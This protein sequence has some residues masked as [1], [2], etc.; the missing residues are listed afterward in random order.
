MKTVLQISCMTTWMYLTLLLCTLRLRW[1]IVCSMYFTISKNHFLNFLIF[2][3]WYVLLFFS[4][5]QGREGSR[6]HSQPS[7]STP[8][9]SPHP[10]IPDSSSIYSLLSIP[11]ALIFIL[12][13]TLFVFL[14]PMYVTIQSP[15]FSH[16]ESSKTENGSHYTFKKAQTPKQA[17][18]QGLHNLITGDLTTHPS[19]PFIMAQSYY[20][21][22][23][24][25][26]LQV[27]QALMVLKDDHKAQGYWSTSLLC[28]SAIIFIK[29]FLICAAKSS[30]MILLV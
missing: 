24:S 10:I 20:R 7:H 22:W 30:A 19:S 12:L 1:Y 5:A 21:P 23:A 26:R 14:L 29:C 6:S 9:P 8:N 18:R 15:Y 28:Y 25:S 2:Q 3:I 17:Y 16:T 13:P 27:N 11:T 4:V